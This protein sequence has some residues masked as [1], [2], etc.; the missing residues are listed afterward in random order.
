LKGLPVSATPV[1]RRAPLS[2]LQQQRFRKAAG[3][4]T[5]IYTTA[6]PVILMV[7]GLLMLVLGCPVFLCR[8][9]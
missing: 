6:L 2:P 1:R 8:G 4:L 7:G 5:R 3:A 9:I